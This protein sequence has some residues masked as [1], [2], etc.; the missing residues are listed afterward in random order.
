MPAEPHHDEQSAICADLRAEHD[1][2]EAV[3]APLDDAGWDTPTPAA[4]WRVRDQIG[5]L[6]YFDRVG[7]LAATE[8]DAF[9]RHRDAALADLEAFGQATEALGREL[10]GT[11]L[12]TAWRD[13]RADML[14]A[15]TTLDPSARVPW[16]GPPMGARSFVTA[17]LMET[18]AHGQ[19]VVDA[20]GAGAQRPPTD[21]LRHIAHI[22]VRTRG[23]SYRVRGLDAPD[24]DVL[25]ALDPPDGGERWVWGDSATD[26]VTG[27]ALDFCL[28]VTQRRH[29]ADTDLV[30]AGPLAASWMAI[31]QAF[32]GGPGRGR[33][34]GQFR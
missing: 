7:L 25:V 24:G 12:L 10:T 20:L 1:A 18:W 14:D 17:R 8:P 19:D 29:L 26:S 2:L 13:A 33:Q 34:P 9:E 4:G 16:Y 31:A 32:A 21:R 6:T 28:V 15:F 27:T 3:V 5:H 22:G 23:W 11:A 30:V